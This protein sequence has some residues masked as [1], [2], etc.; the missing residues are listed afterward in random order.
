MREGPIRVGRPL[1]PCSVGQ[2]GF[3]DL[4][5]VPD[6]AGVVEVVPGLDVADGVAL[7]G[8]CAVIVVGIE[9]R[10]E[11]SVAEVRHR[12]V[13]FAASARLLMSSGNAG[14]RGGSTLEVRKRA[15]TGCGRRGP[16]FRPAADASLALL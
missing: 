2:V 15:G 9:V 10:D 12:E 7:C 6:D 4:G 11:G 1:V 8:E 13:P 3:D 14:L 5:C 16:L